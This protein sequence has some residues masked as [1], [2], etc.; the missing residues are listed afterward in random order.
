[1]DLPYRKNVAAIIVNAEKQ[2]L[3]CQRADKHENWQLPQGGIDPGES[4]LTALYRELE[5]EVLL[6][7]FNIISTIDEPI[8]YEWPREQY[9]RG[10][11]GQTQYFFLVSPT[12]PNWHPSFNHHS[13]IEFKDCKWL[14]VSDFVRH[15]KGTFR[16]SSYLVALR[17][18]KNLYPTLF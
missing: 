6:T 15:I 1:M 16:E 7:E 4:P 18:F 5:E 14:N 8:P 10:F 11:R 13:E 3:T 2:I 17:K 9:S 12:D